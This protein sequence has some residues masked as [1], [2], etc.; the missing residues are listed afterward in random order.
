MLQIQEFCLYEDIEKIKK[1]GLA[2]GGSLD[3]ALVVRE[4]KV[5]NKGGL[6]NEKNLLM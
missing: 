3:N 5:L 2:Q 1:S 4:D 6:R